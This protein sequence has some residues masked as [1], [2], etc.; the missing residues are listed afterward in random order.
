MTQQ[1]GTL[2]ALALKVSEHLMQAVPELIHW[3][4][5]DCPT[6]LMDIKVPHAAYQEVKHLYEHL[7][8]TI[9]GQKL[10]QVQ[11]ESEIFSCAVANG[12]MFQVALNTMLELE[13]SS[14]AMKLTD[15][16]RNIVMDAMR[17]N[18]QKKGVESAPKS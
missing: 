9:D 18:E 2:E 1:D 6:V 4:A 13:G 16:I 15:A 11:F 5:K 8:L 7:D 10:T 12:L 17:T 3:R 14:G